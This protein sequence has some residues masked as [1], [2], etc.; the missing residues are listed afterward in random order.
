M[1]NINWLKNLIYFNFEKIN[2]PNEL[3]VS[4]VKM[5]KSEKLLAKQQELTKKLGQANG[6]EKIELLKQIQEISKLIQKGKMED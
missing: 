1:E 4:Y 6:S 2:K 3:F 5:I